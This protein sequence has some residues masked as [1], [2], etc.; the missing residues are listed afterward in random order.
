MT[1]ED[2]ERIKQ[3]AQQKAKKS[4]PKVRPIEQILQDVK[5]ADAE[6]ES[7]KFVR[8]TPTKLEKDLQE[9]N[10]MLNSNTLPIVKEEPKVQNTDNEWDVPLG[11]PIS[12]FDPSLSYEITGYRP[13]TADKGL[14][15][16]PKVFTEAADTYKTYGRYTQY[17]PGTFI[18]R[19]HWDEEFRRCREGYT[20]GKYTLTGENYFFLNYY[21]LLTVLESNSEVET[22]VEGFPAFFAKQY[23]YFHYLEMCRKLKK[24][25]CAF[26][27]RGVGASEIAASNCARAYTFIEN[28]NNI[29]TGFSEE[30]VSTTLEKV[31]Q[32]L[33]FLN[34]CTEDAFRHVR[35][36]YDSAMLKKAS[37]VDTDGNESGWGAVIQGIVSDKPEKLR[38]K[39][40]YSLYYEEAGNHARLE[41]TYVQGRALVVIN[42]RRVGSRFVF[43]T[44][45][46]ES[47]PKLAGLKKMFYNPDN[48]TMLPYKHNHTRTG[49]WVFT[50]YFIPSFSIWFGTE[51]ERGFDH[52]GVVYEDKAKKSYQDHW[53]T[54]TDP[55]ILLKD[56]AEY[57]F[58]PEDAFIMEGSNAFN[59]EKLSEQQVNIDHGLVEKPKTVR[60]RWGLTGEG[61][62][63]RHST[64]K[65]EYG[66]GG[67]TLM[68]EEPIRDSEGIPIQNLYVIGV[69]G[70]DTSW[71]TTTGQSDLSKYCIIVYK[72]AFGLS[73]PKVVAMYK[74]RPNQVSDA[75]D[76]TI[77]LAQYYN[78][79]VLVEATRVGVIE[80]FKKHGL[81]HHL[82]RKPRF[83]TSGRN[84][85][86]F[87]CPADVKTIERQLQLIN[88]Y[89][90]NYYTSISYQEMIDEFLR[91]SYENKR[92]FDIVAAFGIALLA[93]EELMN[94]PPRAANEKANSEL[95]QIG[96]YHDE[97]G[98]IQFG[99]IP[100]KKPENYGM[101]SNYG[102]HSIRG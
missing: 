32:E 49:D 69:D 40:C 85:Q 84:S 59:M 68:L 23:E 55:S 73:E 67:H 92:K 19:K 15:F 18:H 63:D 10:N 22:R 98:N 76:E 71:D 102:R 89:I 56:K 90:E 87:G 77:K 78:A 26:K 48:Y 97:F 54:V 46:G 52:R 21:R 44:S 43:G 31:W 99:V 66:A 36:K 11:T 34:T 4:Q 101:L 58:T 17:T 82:M 24:D 45:S 80:W 38:G 9:I 51:T 6:K 62:V 53:D 12:Y 74:F 30:Y 75:Y 64:P 37:K 81:Q 50:G 93:D 86:Q 61:T 8:K 96:Y 57:C 39:R 2:I 27:G 88:D 5:E 95:N 35:Q 1:K 79:K 7:K 94:R 47:N 100:K 65:M 60:F 72:R 33:D 42:G 25:G 20:V 83:I 29:V 14:D 28:S 91:Y 16:D 41:D 70:I 3:L 13:I